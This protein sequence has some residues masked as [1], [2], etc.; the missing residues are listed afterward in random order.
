M[1]KITYLLILFCLIGNI[2]YSQTYNWTGATDNGTN[3]THTV[4]SVL[5]TVTTSNNDAQLLNGG[6]FDN[7]SGNVVFTENFHTS[8]S[9]FLTIFIETDG[10]K[11]CNFG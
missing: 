1:K 3:V 10:S 7:S 6:G 9:Q 2:S 8:K 11:S 4:S 5:A